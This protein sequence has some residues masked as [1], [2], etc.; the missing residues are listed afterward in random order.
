MGTTT[1]KICFED[2]R[3]KKNSYE[4]IQLLNE[5]DKNNNLIKKSKTNS[6]NISIKKSYTKNNYKH[7]YTNLININDENN[8]KKEDYINDNNIN[9][10]HNFKILKKKKRNK[11]TNL[12]DLNFY[13]ENALNIIKYKKGELKGKGKFSE[14]YNG[15]CT[16]NLEIVTIKTYNNLSLEKK[17]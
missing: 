14:I 15:L 3:K 17:N 1:H 16:F 8:L 4:E 6:I 2:K 7:K 12:P 10:G 13:K 11:S 9:F 5:D